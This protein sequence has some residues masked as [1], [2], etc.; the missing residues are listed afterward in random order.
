M[1]GCVRVCV[2]LY[3]C[4]G[5]G[6]GGGQAHLFRTHPSSRPPRNALGTLRAAAQPPAPAQPR[7]C[8]CKRP[9]LA[10]DPFACRTPPRL[11]CGCSAG[12][13]SLLLHR[14]DWRQGQGRDQGSQEV[15]RGACVWGGSGGAGHRP[16]SE[17]LRA[18]PA[19]WACCI[20]R[21]ALRCRVARVRGS[22]GLRIKLACVAARPPC[23]VH[24]HRSATQQCSGCSL[25]TCSTCWRWTAGAP[26]PQAARGSG[27]GRRWMPRVRPAPAACLAPV[28]RSLSS[29]HDP[30]LGRLI[31]AIASA[32]GAGAG[33]R[34]T[35][36]SGCST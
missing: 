25:S 16:F 29:L 27:S 6:G 18:S 26:A 22:P 13:V 3:V 32:A 34:V 2:H 15:G 12:L 8:R 33:T 23:P 7:A 36:C 20:A 9:P 31:P 1:W 24:R 5:L 11:P 30:Q 14:L 28:P 17:A 35:A 4:V 21:A 19:R 10:L